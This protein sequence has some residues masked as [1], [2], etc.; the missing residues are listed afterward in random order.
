M[1]KKT[2]ASVKVR[3]KLRVC[4]YLSEAGLERNIPHT[5]SM[6]ESNLTRM[7]GTYRSLY[8]KPDV[9]SL[10]IGVH[11]VKRNAGGF[12]LLYT[13]SRRQLSRRFSKLTALYQHLKAKRLGKMIVQQAIR[14]DRVNGRPYDLRAMV[15]RKPGGK[16]TCTGFM[17]KVGA[18]GKIVTNYFQGGRIVTLRSLFKLQRISAAQRRSRTSQL[19]EKALQVTR[20]LSRKRSGM[21]EMGIDFAYDRSGRFWILEVNSN[22]PQFHPLKKLDRKAYDRMRSFAGSYGRFDNGR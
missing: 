20:A 18:P 11:K 22:H 14:L 19:T 3:G 21:H 5:V 13:V 10:G 16:W 15:Q 6:T 8:I 4:R 9:G 12:E 1:F 7:A 17:A 2:Y